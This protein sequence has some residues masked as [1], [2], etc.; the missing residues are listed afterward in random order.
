MDL[1]TLKK[2]FYA[3]VTPVPIPSQV[4][5]FDSD[6]SSQADIKAFLLFESMTQNQWDFGGV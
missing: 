5:Y 4:Q 1:I 6:A 3:I 2:K